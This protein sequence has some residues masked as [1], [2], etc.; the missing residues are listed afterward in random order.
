MLA[1]E[2]SIQATISP[3]SSSDF[4]IPRSFPDWPICLW[5]S[6]AA[7]DC[8]P[9]ISS[10]IVSILAFSEAADSRRCL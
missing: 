5:I 3:R 2:V 9:I 4:L 8:I 1:T 10:L 7:K 6:E